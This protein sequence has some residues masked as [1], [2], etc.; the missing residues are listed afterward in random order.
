MFLQIDLCL[1]IV[2]SHLDTHFTYIKEWEIFGKLPVWISV[3]VLAVSCP[4]LFFM[5]VGV[6]SLRC[7]TSPCFFGCT[8][9]EWQKGLQMCVQ[10]GH[11][12]PE[13]CACWM[14]VCVCDLW[15]CPSQGVLF[16]CQESTDSK[17]LLCGQNLSAFNG[18][19]IRHTPIESH[20]SCTWVPN[21]NCFLFSKYIFGWLNTSLYVVLTCASGFPGILILIYLVSWSWRSGRD[22]APNAHAKEAAHETGEMGE[23]YL[24]MWYSEG[25]R[26]FQAHI[27]LQCQSAMCMF[28][29]AV[30]V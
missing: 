22:L 24:S 21:N 23:L 30:E 28:A 19:N 25:H 12:D 29:S 14:A 9:G 18:T 13:V 16:N 26:H 1:A 15:F 10:R 27:D 11:L 5:A 3:V 17:F 20:M 4:F 6:Q 7:N 8:V 2:D